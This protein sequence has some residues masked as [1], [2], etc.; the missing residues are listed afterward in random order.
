MIFLC[1]YV[2]SHTTIFPCLKKVSTFF[3]RVSRWRRT[4]SEHQIF[5]CLC[6]YFFLHLLHH[7]RDRNPQ[8]LFEMVNLEPQQIVVS[9]L[10]FGA[11]FSDVYVTLF[12][13]RPI[14]KNQPSICFFANKF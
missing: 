1:T 7:P 10:D 5:K 2:T 14:K 6:K 3:Q 11:L 9:I 12:S 8:N 4:M 13:H